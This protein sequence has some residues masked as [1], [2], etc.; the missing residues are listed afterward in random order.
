MQV[1]QVRYRNTQGTLMRIL[2]AASRRGLE[3]T[4]VQSAPRGADF[5]VTLFLDANPKHT[6][7]LIRE[8][9][10]IMDVIEVPAPSATQNHEASWAA[11]H[12]PAS[13]PLQ[14]AEALA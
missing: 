7:Q 9:Y 5:L 2:N 3:L 1:F 10:S 12:P 11:P 8:W 13:A 6:A 14:P 4:T